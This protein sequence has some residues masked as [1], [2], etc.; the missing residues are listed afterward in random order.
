MSNLSPL[1]RSA[2][3]NWTLDRYYERGENYHRQGR[4]QRPRREGRTLKAECQGSQPNPYHVEAKLDADGISWAECSCPVGG[5]CK[6]AVALL[7]TWVESPDKFESQ[8]SLETTLQEQPQDKLVEMI[9]T[10]VGRH[11]DLERLVRLSSTSISAAIDPEELR[12]QI[13]SVFQDAGP[14]QDY[15]YDRDPYAVVQAVA[16]D[17]EP[18]FTRADDYRR[19]DRF[20]DATTVYRVLIEEIRDHYDQFWDEEGKLSSRASEATRELGEILSEAEDP[21]LRETI[22]RVLFDAYMWDLDLGGYGIGDW[23]H[24]AILEY[25]APDE[26]QQV[27][28]WIRDRIP[29]QT[30]PPDPDRR[31]FVMSK[32][33]TSS[34][35]SNWKRKALG[36]FLLDLLADTLDDEK[37]LRICQATGRITEL[38]ERFLERDRLDEALDAAREASD[39]EVYKLTSIFEE[40][41][42]EDALYDLVLDRL[43]NDTDRRLVTWLRNAAADREHLGRALDLSRRLFQ[44]Q[45]SESAYER[46][47]S[48]AQQLDRWN[49]V[50]ADLHDQ[51]R[52]EGNYALLT[53]IHLVDDNVEAA[54]E[55]VP[56]A[57]S[58]FSWHYSRSPLPIEVAEAAEEEYPEDAIQL[59]T[60][61]GRSLIA[62]RGR[63]NYREAAKYFQRV[64]ALYDR[65]QPGAWSD[66]LEALYDDELHRLPAARDEFEKA[67]LL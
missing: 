46:L 30:D 7:L 66:V 15:Y 51:L 54:L 40:H 45:T 24:E 65:T 13:Q 42:A 29:G 61:R 34:W 3:H 39:Y 2:V 62:E 33:E 1:S 36:S 52:G 31:V 26:R 43:D 44:A 27:A 57:D 67:D 10:M 19:H 25:A 6:H 56:K 50:Q 8:D 48:V 63:D 53:R 47:R 9:L 22:L 5:G 16:N 23:A 49:Q 11:P 35:S 55:T 17:L 4:I 59:Y 32:D 60:E 28:E 14:G 38:V 21:D 41:D 37:Y 20:H 58:L 18:F 64:K 12:G